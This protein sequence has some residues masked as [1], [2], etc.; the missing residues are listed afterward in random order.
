MFVTLCLLSFSTLIQRKES[1]GQLPALSHHTLE[2]KLNCTFLVLEQ[3][4][5]LYAITSFADD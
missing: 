5:W 2:L 1:V 4:D 3:H